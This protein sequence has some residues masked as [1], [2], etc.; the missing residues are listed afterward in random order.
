MGIA[1]RPIRAEDNKEMQKII[2]DILHKHKLNV[3]GTA[4]FDPQLGNLSS[5]YEELPN[6]EYWVL[7]K[8]ERVIGGVGVGPFGE[9]TDVAELQKYYIKEEFQGKGYGRLLYDRAWEF[10][11]EQEFTRFY[12]ETMD[13]LDAAN[14]V[15]KHLGFRQLEKPLD[16]SEHGLMNRWFIKN[17]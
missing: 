16:G 15:Y 10:V 8:N 17:I 3:P 14:V 11:Q 5:F 7:T 9:Y 1:V 13:R 2:Q 6:G 12:L 4:Y